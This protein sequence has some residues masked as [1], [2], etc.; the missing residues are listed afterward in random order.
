MNYSLLVLSA[1]ATGSSNLAAARFAAA[2]LARGHTILRVFF[3][4]A[5]VETGL[6]TRVSP[7]DELATLPLWTT[8]AEDHEVELICCISSALK[9]GVVDQRESARHNLQAATLHPAFSI[10]G[11][12]LL[13]EATSKSD[14]LVT[15]GG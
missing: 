5:G 12:G 3:L 14:R 1:P 7:Q 10:G 2:V 11:L 9:R 6:A 8:L 13:V 4:D 15:F